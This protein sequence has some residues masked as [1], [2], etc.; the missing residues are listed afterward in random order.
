MNFIEK[1]LSFIIAL[2]LKAKQSFTMFA[3]LTILSLI[4]LSVR[5]FFFALSMLLIFKPKAF[6]SSTICMTINSFPTGLIIQP[7]AFIYISVRMIQNSISI[8]LIT[9]PFPNISR[10]ISPNLL[11]LPFPLAILPLTLVRN[12]IIEFYLCHFC[13][14]D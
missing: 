11:S 9:S 5:P 2:I 6:V 8:G 3:A 12:T 10:P 13:P 7:L 1:E 14:T 4:I